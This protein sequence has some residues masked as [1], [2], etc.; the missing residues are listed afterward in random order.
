[1]ETAARSVDVGSDQ[2]EFDCLMMTAV[3]GR[4]AFDEN[5]DFVRAC[6]CASSAQV[7]ELSKTSTSLER[8]LEDHLGPLDTSV[9]LWWLQ[10]TDAD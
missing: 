8:K 2:D 10:R 7:D 4:D 5:A 3:L 1:M 6:G 9:K